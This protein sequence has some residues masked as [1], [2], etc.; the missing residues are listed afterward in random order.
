MYEVLT[1]FAVVWLFAFL[2]RSTHHNDVQLVKHALVDDETD[3]MSR[4]YLELKEA[5]DDYFRQQSVH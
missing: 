1:I 5:R 3:R 4:K 2:T